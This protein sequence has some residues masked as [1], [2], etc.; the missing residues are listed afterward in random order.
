MVRALADREAARSRALRSIG[1]AG[2]LGRQC[3]LKL[4]G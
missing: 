4:G 3:S 1:I 2:A